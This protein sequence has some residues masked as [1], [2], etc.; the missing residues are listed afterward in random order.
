MFH[1]LDLETLANLARDAEVRWYGKDTDVCQQGDPSDEL[2][3]L[4]A[5]TADALIKADGDERIV[6]A[7]GPGQVIGE[8]GVLTWS[9]RTATVRVSSSHAVILA[10]SAARLHSLVEQDTHVTKWMLLTVCERLQNM[11]SRADVAQGA[12]A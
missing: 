12:P 4:H 9:E 6:G 11:L 2:Y 1:G 7:I 5:G 3:V 8:L 10:L